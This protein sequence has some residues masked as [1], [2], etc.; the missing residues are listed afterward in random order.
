MQVKSGKEIK[1]RTLLALTCTRKK[2]SKG[3]AFAIL[4]SR[5]RVIPIV[6]SCSH[7]PGGDGNQGSA[8]ELC[9]TGRVLIQG[10]VGKSVEPP[11]IGSRPQGHSE[12]GI[13][14]GLVPRVPQTFFLYQ[15]MKKSSNYVLLEAS[16][17]I[18]T[19]TYR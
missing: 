19:P 13:C 9:H 15:I 6:R 7:L 11:L 1:Y 3:K 12:D 8:S 2:Q 14:S 4:H 17:R 16:I 10:V 5:P 18:Q